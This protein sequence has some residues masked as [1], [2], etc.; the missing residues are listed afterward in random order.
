MEVEMNATTR[1]I[2]SNST[3]AA[4]AT[5]LCAIIL[6]VVPQTA[7]AQARGDF[8]ALGAASVAEFEGSSNQRIQPLAIGRIDLGRSGS[9]RL[10]GNSVQY[11]FLPSTSRW[12]LGPMVSYRIGRD[13]GVDDPVIARMREVDD[14]AEVGMWI[15]YA[16]PDAILGGDRLLLD[17]EIRSGDGRLFSLIAGY[18]FPRAG[19]LQIGLDARATFANDKY[20]QT[21]FSIDED[22]RARSGL[23]LYE[24][25][26]GFRDLVLGVSAAYDF[27][28]N[29]LVTGRI[30]V[31]RLAGDAA[32]SPI[33][34][35]RGD[36]TSPYL[37]IALGYRF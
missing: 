9:L 6:S 31:K 16:Y 32:D 28:D 35:E 1:R 30:G 25:K 21:N 17:A 27:A 26:G 3:S 12:S 7:L 34:T 5:A 29:W 33:V 14:T 19:A 4:C 15:Q 8:I 10:F 37:G 2:V 20:M 22:N 13:S 24:A 36:K 18:L 23:P 11:N